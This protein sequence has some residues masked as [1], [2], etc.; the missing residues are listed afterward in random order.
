MVL[1]GLGAIFYVDLDFF[2]TQTCSL[3]RL[4]A[5]LWR[6]AGHWGDIGTLG[7]TGKD[8]W[9]SRLGFFLIFYE[10][11]DPISKVL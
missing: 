10:F 1:A 3:A 6:P 2:G 11:G 9:R 8:T 4:V 7:S 5:S